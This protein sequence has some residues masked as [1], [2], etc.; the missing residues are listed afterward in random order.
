MGV[1]KYPD[2]QKLGY[3]KGLAEWQFAEGHYIRDIFILLTKMPNKY[4][5]MLSVL[6]F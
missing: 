1:V 3:Q 6:L 4:K 5:L 2:R